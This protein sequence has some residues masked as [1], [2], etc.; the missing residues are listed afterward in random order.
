M[1]RNSSSPQDPG[2]P[3]VRTPYFPLLVALL[4]AAWWPAGAEAQLLDRRPPPRTR[5]TRTDLLERAWP[6]YPEWLAMFTEVVDGNPPFAGQGW[7]RK[8]IS[9]TRFDWKSTATRLDRN[10]DGAIDRAEL[11]AGPAVYRRLDRD[12]GRPRSPRPTST[13]WATAGPSPMGVLFFSNNAFNT[14][15][16]NGDAKVTRAEW[17]GVLGFAFADPLV[18]VILTKIA[19]EIEARFAAVE[20]DGIAFLTLAD[21]QEA[22]TRTMKAD[23]LA[24]F[25]APKMV[26]ES[27][28]NRKLLVRGFLRGDLGSMGPGPDLDAPAPDFTLSTVDGR[29]EV[30]LS[31]LDRSKPVVL[32]FGN[33]TCGPFRKHAGSLEV[34]RRRYGDRAHFL[35]IYSREAHPSDGWQMD[36]NVLDKVVIRQPRD[37]L[38]RTKVAT[39]CLKALGLDIPVLVD[40]MDDR[41][42]TRYSGTPSRLYLIDREGKIAYKGGRAPFGFKP[43]ELEQSLLLLLEADAPPKAEASSNPT[44]PR[45]R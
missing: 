21:Y 37:Y 43:A 5:L 7:Y 26:P 18:R 35:M 38:E 1:N 44:P 9:R 42:A 4:F 39:T 33:F 16:R 28:V 45:G 3:D 8:G 32:I 40:G 14:S 12:A 27:P 24:A 41:V 19:R 23:M 22:F 11:G 15:D 20:K 31:K 17:D 13:S 30:T 34:L 36:D 2:R 25:S 29:S 10:H 6:G